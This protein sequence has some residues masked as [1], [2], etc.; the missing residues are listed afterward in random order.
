MR[1]PTWQINY[2][3]T[4]TLA[5]DRVNLTCQAA[6]L[7]V[8]QLAPVP[9]QIV[10]HEE[11]EP[12]PKKHAHK[13]PV[14]VRHKTSRVRKATRIR[15]SVPIMTREMRVGINPHTTMAAQ[16]S[17]PNTLKGLSSALPFSVMRRAVAEAQIAITTENEQDRKIFCQPTSY[18]NYR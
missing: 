12:D 18:H 5:I 8:S 11:N 3:H 6:R 14:A 9:T 17:V 13:D 1:D 4:N 2:N 10:H 15:G 7:H 16:W